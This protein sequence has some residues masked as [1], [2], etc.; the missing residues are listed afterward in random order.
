MV[1][2]VFVIDL[3]YLKFESGLEN[4]LCL[5]G[6]SIGVLRVSR[7]ILEKESQASV[8]IYLND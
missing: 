4:H 3:T 7:N 5:K 1:R 6:G 8:I 2:R